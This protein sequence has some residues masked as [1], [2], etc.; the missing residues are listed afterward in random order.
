MPRYCPQELFLRECRDF[1]AS[2]QIQASELESAPKPL[3]RRVVGDLA[4]EMNRAFTQVDT[5]VR[6][7]NNMVKN[8]PGSTVIARNP[9]FWAK[10][11]DQGAHLNEDGI[12][13]DL[14]GIASTLE[15]NLRL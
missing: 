2:L 1:K 15:T 10:N 9:N 8:D 11:T 4:R 7:A 5:I 14:Q 13:R 6:L 12:I 3:S